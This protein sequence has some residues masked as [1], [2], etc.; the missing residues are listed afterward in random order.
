MHFDDNAG[1]TVRIVQTHGLLAGK[2]SRKSCHPSR[3]VSA[4]TMVTFINQTVLYPLSRSFSFVPLNCASEVI[5]KI[6]CVTKLD[7]VAGVRQK[8]VFNSI[9]FLI[10][11]NC[12]RELNC[13]IVCLHTFFSPLM[14]ACV[15]SCQVELRICT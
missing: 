11:F 10:D 7:Q 6:A 13:R 3:S 2:R 8:I 12:K 14:F 15:L 1:E 9:E 5:D 4:I